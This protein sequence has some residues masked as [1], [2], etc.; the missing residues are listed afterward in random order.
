MK[1]AVFSGTFQSFLLNKGYTAFKQK[2]MCIFGCCAECVFFRHFIAFF[3]RS[4][5]LGPHKSGGISP[6]SPQ[7]QCAGG[8]FLLT[9]AHFSTG[10][11]W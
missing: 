3:H 9:F 8:A 2:F 1:S 6:A 10:D 5:F 4:G 11:G 7:A